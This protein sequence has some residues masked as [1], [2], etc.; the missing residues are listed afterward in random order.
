MSGARRI[1]AVRPLAAAAALSLL[2]ARPSQA[3]HF[4]DTADLK[5]SWKLAERKDGKPIGF[6]RL[7]HGDSFALRLEWKPDGLAGARYDQ[8]DEIPSDSFTALTQEY[9][10]GAAWHETAGSLDSQ[11]VKRYPGLQQEWVLKG[12]GGE[13]GWLGSG[14]DRGRYFLVFRAEPP[15]ARVPVTGPLRFSP[16]LYAFLD[17]SS[18]WLHVQCKELPGT[19]SASPS[20]AKRPNPAA[21]KSAGKPV[22]FSPGDDTHWLVRVDGRKPLRLQAWLEEPGSPALAEIRKAIGKVPDASQVE[23]AKDLSQMLLGEGQIFLVKLAQRLP[24]AFTWPSWQIQD[25]KGGQVPYAEFL[26]LVRRQAE[27]GEFLPA[28]RVQDPAFRLGVDLYYR[29]TIHLSAEGDQ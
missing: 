25:Y 4:P 15:I 12:Y 7:A 5:N 18:E 1:P 17:T 13:R 10:N 22:C 24:S 29:G 21:A 26:P 11:V 8:P 6:Y 23:Y 19:S 2:L 14:L 9:G 3:V 27:P 28:F 16:G 20:S